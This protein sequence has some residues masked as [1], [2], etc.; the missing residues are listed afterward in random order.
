LE[1]SNEAK[2]IEKPSSDGVSDPFVKIF[3]DASDTSVTKTILRSDW[4]KYKENNK[5]HKNVYPHE[6]AGQKTSGKVVPSS[7]QQ[8]ESIP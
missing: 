4:E 7:L 5:H 2:D 6:V 8:Q 1:N 3:P